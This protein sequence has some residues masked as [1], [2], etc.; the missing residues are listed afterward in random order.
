V[1]HP[2]EDPRGPTHTAARMPTGCGGSNSPAG[3]DTGASSG[4]EA[5]PTM[6]PDAGTGL[7]GRRT[8]AVASTLL[9]PGR[10]L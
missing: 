7:V 9:L 6:I 4:G 10:G 2:A 1:P 3:T 8:G 5:T